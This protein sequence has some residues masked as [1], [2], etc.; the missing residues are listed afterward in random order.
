[1]K[2]MMLFKTLSFPF[3]EHSHFFRGTPLQMKPQKPPENKAL[4]RD[5]EAYHDALIRPARACDFLGYLGGYLGPLRFPM[6]FPQVHLVGTSSSI[7][8]ACRRWEL[9]GKRK[10]S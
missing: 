10:T 5:H 4:L 7:I 8:L 2:V 1:M 3:G 6:I 9:A